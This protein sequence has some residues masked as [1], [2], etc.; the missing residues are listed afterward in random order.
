MPP[1]RGLAEGQQIRLESPASRKP[2]RSTDLGV[3]LVYGQ[4]RTVVASH[5]AHRGV[6]PWLRLNDS[7]VGQRGLGQDAG[8]IARSQGGG[9][10]LRVVERHDAHTVSR[11]G[12]KPQQLGDEPATARGEQHLVGMTVVAT[13]E[14]HHHRTARCHPR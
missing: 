1:R 13:V 2:A 7:N 11:P 5:L 4:Q 9:E 8:D 10:C 6:E 3:R 12:V 14:H